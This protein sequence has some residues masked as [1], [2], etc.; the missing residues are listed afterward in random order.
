[1]TILADWDKVYIC[2]KT[3]LNNIAIQDAA[4]A[5]YT[6]CMNTCISNNHLPNNYNQVDN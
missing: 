6:R 2:G 1:M 3:T 5:G 4:N